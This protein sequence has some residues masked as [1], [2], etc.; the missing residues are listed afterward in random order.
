METPELGIVAIPE[1]EDDEEAASVDEPQ[2]S[3]PEEREH[4]EIQALLARIGRAMGHDIYIAR[5]D[6]NQT[7]QGK[8]LAELPGVVDVLPT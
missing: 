7:W 3:A 1:P 2:R 4:T 8:P 5:N 6:R